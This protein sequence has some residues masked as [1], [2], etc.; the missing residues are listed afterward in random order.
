MERMATQLTADAQ[1]KN[2]TWPMVELT[3]FE[4]IGAAA[5]EQSGAELIQLVPIV[6]RR[7]AEKWAE[8]SL[9]LFGSW[10][11][12]SKATVLTRKDSELLV[13]DYL[14]GAPLPYI[15]DL[16]RSSGDAAFVP[17]TE[18]TNNEFFLPIFAQSP[19][20][21]SPLSL[22]F[23]IITVAPAEPFGAA[24]GAREGVFAKVSELGGTIGY[25]I[26]KEDHE[27]YHERLVAWD[28]RNSAE[29][30]PHSVFY[31]PIFEHVFGYK[32]K[33]YQ[34]QE[35]NRNLALGSLPLSRIVGYL[36]SV[37]AWDRY[38]ANL[39]PSGVDG[40]TAVLSN[41][42]NQTYTYYLDGSTVSTYDPVKLLSKTLQQDL[43]FCCMMLLLIRRRIFRVPGIFTSRHTKIHKSSFLSGTIAIPKRQIFQIIAHT[44][45]ASTR[46]PSLS[47]TT[48]RIRPSLLLVRW[49]VCLC[50]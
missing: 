7:V 26:R 16:N 43:S 3:S 4:V 15:V 28:R 25:A 37:V 5:R 46:P 35:A 42:C 6:T 36:V 44:P 31:F 50:S 27:L 32:Q 10:Y 34:S 9:N 48:P 18:N 47:A 20:P 40:I 45:S 8:H 41:S 49:P 11:E 13:T 24:A 14:P 33:M 12:E 38:V 39:L 29:D 2:L 30:N 21:F 19:P 23:N 1:G 22:N 17:A